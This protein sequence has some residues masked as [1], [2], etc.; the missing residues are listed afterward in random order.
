MDNLKSW[1][2]WLQEEERRKWE[3][4]GATF[5]RLANC[6]LLHLSTF[7]H[8]RGVAYVT[9]CIRARGRKSIGKFGE[10]QS[11]MHGVLCW[12]V[13]TLHRYQKVLSASTSTPAR[14]Q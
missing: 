5:P 6:L 7:L 3:G 2:E 8:Q 13:T 12:L 11:D 10:R 14:S 1:R 9:L 4:S